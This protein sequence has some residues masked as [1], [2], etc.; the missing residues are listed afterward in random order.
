MSLAETIVGF[1]VGGQVLISGP[2]YQHIY[3][4]LHTVA[5]LASLKGPDNKLRKLG[6]R[7]RGNKLVPTKGKSKFCSQMWLQLAQCCA[8]MCCLLLGCSI[9][10][11]GLVL[12]C[13]MLYCL[14]DSRLLCCATLCRL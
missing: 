3:G 14:T 1:P 12:H 7:T 6:S 10:G 8:M 4:K 13:A 5:P 2:T 11:L 9:S